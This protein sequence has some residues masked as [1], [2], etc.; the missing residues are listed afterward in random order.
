MGS[1]HATSISFSPAETMP[2][3][4]SKVAPS[5]EEDVSLVFVVVVALRSL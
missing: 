1:T 2:K 5:T 4:L 3:D